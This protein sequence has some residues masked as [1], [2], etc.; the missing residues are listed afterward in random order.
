MAEMFPR[1]ISQDVSEDERTSAWLLKAKG[2]YQADK[3]VEPFAF[4]P[5][6][7]PLNYSRRIFCSSCCP[8]HL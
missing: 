4:Q 5:T 7:G 6:V 1:A 8:S 3:K 2:L